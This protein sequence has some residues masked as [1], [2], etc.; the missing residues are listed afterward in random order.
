MIKINNEIIFDMK[1]TILITAIVVL[2]VIK[3][4]AQTKV[5]ADSASTKKIPMSSK[6]VNKKLA[7]EKDSTVN[8]LNGNASLLPP[9]HTFKPIINDVIDCNPK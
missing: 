4:L 5:L 7:I 6:R 8:T 1:V 3:V 9:S 2:S